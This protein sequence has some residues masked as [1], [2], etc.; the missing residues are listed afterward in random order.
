MPE[1]IRTTFTASLK[2]TDDPTNVTLVALAV[3]VGKTHRLATGQIVTWTASFLRLKAA[4][5]IG[6]P[7]NIDLDEEGQPTGHSRRVAGA[8]TNAWFDEREQ[9]VMVEATLWPHYL[10]T[11]VARIKEL[12]AAKGLQVSMELIPEGEMLSN[13]DG[14]VTPVDGEFSGLGIVRVGADPRNK[15]FLVAAMAEDDKHEESMTRNDVLSRLSKLIFGDEDDL[16]A[17]D[18]EG[19]PPQAEL[20]ARD[21]HNAEIAAA[22]EGSFEWIGR[23]L[24]EHLR[25][26]RASDDYTYS[27]VIA[28]YPKYAI[29]QEGESYYRI[30]FTRKGREVEFQAPVEVDPTYTPV[31]ASASEDEDAEHPSQEDAAL[32][33]DLSEEQKAALRAELQAELQPQLDELKAERDA[34]LAEKNQAAA[35]AAKDALAATRA[36]ELDAILPVKS[37]DGKARRLAAMRDLSDEAFASLK[38]EL[39]D[40]AAPLGGINSN[41]EGAQVVDEGDAHK[42][43]DEQ[44][45]KWTAEAHAAL[46]MP[47][48]DKE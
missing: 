29:Y 48:K 5:F 17:L 45:D 10:P 21:A 3:G 46:G 15:V 35:E 38:A 31:E 27:Y 9:G 8:I 44:I 6:K 24:V 1:P 33:T 19:M 23:R 2:R 40:A 36:Q 4:S 30:D 22:H 20:A 25:E 42:V 34:L 47:A 28:T 14:S 32:A 18:A 16:S 39:A 26:A 7:V 41:A 11:T 43:S 13:E 37:E 12:G